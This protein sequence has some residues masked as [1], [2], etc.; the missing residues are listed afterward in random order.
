MSVKKT[1]DELLAT[2]ANEQLQEVLD[3]AQFVSARQER[4]DWRRF[5]VQRLARAYGPDE[6]EYTEADLK[7]ELNP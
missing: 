4:E 6:P 2:F 5:G 3:F 7:P 1:L